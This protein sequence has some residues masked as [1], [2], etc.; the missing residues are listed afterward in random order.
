M[1][2]TVKGR[3]TGKV[4][5][6]DGPAP[7]DHEVEVAVQFPDVDRSDDKPAASPR[8]RWDEA[9]ALEPKITT[10]ASDELTR[11]RRAE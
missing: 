2:T 9:A 5:E 3:F 10:A 7:V 6:L 1:A 4:V 11:Q 8:F